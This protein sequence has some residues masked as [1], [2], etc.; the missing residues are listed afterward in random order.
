MVRTF[1]DS[2]VLLA[3]VRSLGRDRERA[4]EILEHPDRRFLT[5]PFVHLEL[6]PKAIFHKKGLE[7]AFYD[8][9]FNAAEWFRDLDKIEAAAQIE[10]SKS[11]LA[12][13]DA[14]HLAAANLSRADEFVTTERPGKPIYR[15]SLIRI[16]HLFD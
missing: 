4:L 8:E 6:V 10:A 15:T 16:V 11:G 1:L 2:G 13:M 7:K 5:S 9:Y 12:A 3:A 14:L